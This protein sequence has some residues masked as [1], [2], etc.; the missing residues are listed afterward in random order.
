MT[1]SGDGDGGGTAKLTM[2][3]KKSFSTLFIA[4]PGL[5]GDFVFW[6]PGHWTG[7]KVSTD[8]D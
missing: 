8:S 4:G 6:K 3:Q 1:K 5:F 7:S 2:E